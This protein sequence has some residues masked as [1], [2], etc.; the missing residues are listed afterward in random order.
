MQC[1]LK[2]N[3]LL[4][5]HFIFRKER[6]METQRALNQYYES[7]DENNRL[8]FRYGMVEYLTTMHYIKKYLRPGMRIPEI[9]AA[10]GRYFHKI[11]HGR[12]GRRYF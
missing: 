12:D 5:L 8:C 6:I 10:T 4:A 9:S 3:V 2:R 1:K 7:Y 11:H